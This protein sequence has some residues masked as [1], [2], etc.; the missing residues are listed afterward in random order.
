MPRRNGSCYGP[1]P[2]KPPCCR[3]RVTPNICRC[4]C[5]IIKQSSPVSLQAHQ[6]QA[7]ARLPLQRSGHVGVCCAVDSLHLHLPPVH[8]CHCTCR[9]D[10][11]APH[12]AFTLDPSRCLVHVSLVSLCMLTA[13]YVSSLRGCSLRSHFLLMRGHSFSQVL[14]HI[15]IC[16]LMLRCYLQP[17]RQQETRETAAVFRCCQTRHRCC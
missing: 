9:L 8:F 5:C 4:S 12:T 16:S 14:Y 7:I 1:A 17:W 15:S 3:Y 6:L 2:A 13:R 11:L 10:M